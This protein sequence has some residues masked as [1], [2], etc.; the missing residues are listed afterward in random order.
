[1]ARNRL[2][3]PGSY[4]KNFVTTQVDDGP[5][6][7]IYFGLKTKKL[8]HQLEQEARRL[9][10]KYKLEKRYYEWVKGHIL[11]DREP[12]GYA[13]YNEDYLT[14]LSL[15]KNWRKIPEANLTSGEKRF[16]KEK[17]KE[18]FGVS[19]GRPPKAVAEEY[20]RFLKL[21]SLSKNK[22]RRMKDP[23]NVLT[24]FSGRSY[25]EL[26]TMSKKSTINEIDRL[27]RAKLRI[28]KRYSYLKS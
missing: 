27:E 9:L 25:K 19:G 6:Y 20:G 8:N 28:K 21:L 7:R 10:K 18:K 17:I 12:H 13:F 15:T 16:I 22:N 2:G 3:I 24:T 14:E 26:A 4:E 23:D 5:S 1:M 11:N